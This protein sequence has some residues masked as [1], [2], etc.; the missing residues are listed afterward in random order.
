M[1]FIYWIWKEM[2]QHC[3]EVSGLNGK[4]LDSSLRRR[5]INVLALH[6]RFVL[7]RQDGVKVNMLEK[8]RGESRKGEGKKK[9]K[10]ISV[11][12]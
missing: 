11:V 4:A 6:F 2:E 8:S 7:R 12:E 3:L 10:P 1:A 5:I 9:E